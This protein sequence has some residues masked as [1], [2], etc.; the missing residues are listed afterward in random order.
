MGDV[1]KNI[2]R[3]EVGCKCGCGFD[4]LDYET[5]QV[6]QECCDHF[7]E[8]LMSTV[9][10]IINSGCRCEAHNMAVGGSANSKH[11]EARA[12]D[13]K[14]VGVLPLAVYSYLNTK[15]PGKYGIGSYD[16]FTHLDTRTDGPAR[17]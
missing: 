6:V 14:I 5:L 10:C 7:A 1:T 13:F 11:V 2:S 15:Y 9:Y 17:W 16:T 8:E 12:I 3:Y 4:T